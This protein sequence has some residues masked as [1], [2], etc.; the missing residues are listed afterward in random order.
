VSS[1]ISTQFVCSDSG[2][3]RGALGC[4]MQRFKYTSSITTLMPVILATLMCASCNGGISAVASGMVTPRFIVCA[5]V[6]EWASAAAADPSALPLTLIGCVAPFVPVIVT[7]LGDGKLF[8]APLNRVE[9]H[10]VRCGSAAR[11]APDSVY[12]IHEV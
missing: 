4:R 3:G 7:V 12:L 9:R 8:T 10:S 11:L 6:P 2:L 5:G 1:V